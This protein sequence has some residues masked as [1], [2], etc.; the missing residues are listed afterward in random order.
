MKSSLALLLCFFASV[1]SASADKSLVLARE[2]LLSSSSTPQA[3]LLS[4][5]AAAKNSAAAPVMAEYAYVLAYA[6]LGEAALYNLDRALITE[7]LNREVRFYLAEILNSAGLE[8]PSAEQGAPVPAWLK[9]GPLKLPVLE[10]PAPEGDFEAASAS[11]NLLMAQRR[12]AESAVLYDRLCARVPDNARCYAG[13]AISLEKLG[14]YRSAAGE[15]KKDMRL[16]T[17]P[18]HRAVAAAYAADL[19]KRPPLRFSQEKIT[20]KGR[21]L[22]FLGGNVTRSGG[23]T[24]GSV[25]GRLGRFLSE[26]VDVSANASLN[27]GNADSDYNGVTLGLGGRY[28]APLALLPLNWTFAAKL[29]RVPAPEDNTTFLLSPG[30]SY[31]TVSGS[32]DLYLDFALSGAFSGSRTLSMGYTVYFGGGK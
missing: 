18:E 7:P 15:A 2:S 25:S 16:T 8:G 17:S 23:A 19:E 13:Y 14:A 30:L 26:R 28:N 5:L 9:G 11:I 12:Y 32:L 4:Y 3:A 27:C 22:A 20:M 6:G 31:F 10:V 1:S 21:Y 29:E 24:T